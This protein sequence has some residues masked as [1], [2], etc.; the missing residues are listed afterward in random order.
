[1]TPN[2]VSIDQH[3]TVGEAA[4]LLT[5]AGIGAA[6]VVGAAGR[7]VGVVS[8]ADIA[9]H[10]RE[11]ACRR[12]AHDRPGRDRPARPP[13]TALGRRFLWELAAG[14]EVRAI[15]TPYALCVQPDTPL[16]K[17]VEA[18]LARHTHR[19]FVVNEGGILVGTICTLDVLR[20][21]RR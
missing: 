9:R 21:L 11:T 3:A 5:R 1:M 18:M 16:V 8:W 4:A 10:E 2:P 12:S 14:T 15:M 20:Q 13:A 7:P 6:P 19:L 17:V